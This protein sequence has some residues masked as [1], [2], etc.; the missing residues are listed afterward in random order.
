M[1]LLQ[2]PAVDKMKE[3]LEVIAKALVD[4]PEQVQVHA[5][6][7]EGAVVL[8]LRVHP[9][10]LEK[11]IAGNVL[12]WISKGPSAGFH[13]GTDLECYFFESSLLK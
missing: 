5:I 3:L 7:G 6:E 4:D 13:S 12:W 11:P 8:V 1:N 2:V 10:N 9:S